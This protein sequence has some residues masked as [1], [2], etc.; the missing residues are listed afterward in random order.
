MKHGSSDLHFGLIRPLKILRRLWDC[1][2][3]QNEKLTK[4]MMSQVQ[5][6]QTAD[7]TSNP[8]STSSRKTI[9][10]LRFDGEVAKLDSNYQLPEPADG[11]AVIRTAKAAVSATDIQICSGLFSFT[12]TLG[13]E[14][15]GIVE[16]INGEAQR[17]LIGKRVVGSI[18]A[19]CG[20]CDMCMA[21]L[22]AH[23]RDRTVL[24]RNGRDG[25]LA[26]SFILAASHLT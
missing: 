13:H 17:E 23:C 5:M 20:K 11:E 1:N 26:D 18:D 4:M 7:T 10:A 2:L 22:K 6:K 21:G 16:S 19:V 8:S 14:F 9:R 3:K 15:V 25:C 24:G 12:G